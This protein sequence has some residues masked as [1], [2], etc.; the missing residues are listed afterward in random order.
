MWGHHGN[1]WQLRLKEDIVF[2]FTWPLR[3]YL[4]VG[5]TELRVLGR[6]SQSWIL[7]AAKFSFKHMNIRLACAQCS[8]KKG[9]CKLFAVNVQPAAVMQRCVYL[10]VFSQ[11][12]WGRT[13]VR[14]H[15]TDEDDLNSF[16]PILFAIIIIFFASY[17]L[18]FLSKLANPPPLSVGPSGVG[19]NMCWFHKHMLVCDLQDNN[20]CCVLL[21]ELQDIF[22]SRHLI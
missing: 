13:G 8:W 4:H 12:L 14:S 18:S 17:V 20:C 2:T 10:C 15:G 7:R 21:L 6:S 11:M 3:H 9:K 16:I 5:L 22:S 19:G 1:S